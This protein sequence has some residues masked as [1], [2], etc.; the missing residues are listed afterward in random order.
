MD[1]CMGFIGSMKVSRRLSPQFEYDDVCGF[2][3][4][5]QTFASWNGE[6]VYCIYVM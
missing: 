3:L 2:D 6:V 5:H 4:P 1:A